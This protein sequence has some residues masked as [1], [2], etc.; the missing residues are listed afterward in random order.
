MNIKSIRIEERISHSFLPV[1]AHHA[2]CDASHVWE[3]ISHAWIHR[4]HV[5]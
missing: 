3:Y 2:P 4:C 1:S 5:S